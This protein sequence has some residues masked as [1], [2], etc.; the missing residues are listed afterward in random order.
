MIEHETPSDFDTLSERLLPLALRGE[1]RRKLRILAE[2]YRTRLSNLDNLFD[3]KRLSCP[4]CESV[5]NVIITGNGRGDAKK[6]LCRA[7]HDSEFTGRNSTQFRFSTYT[8]FEALKVYQD[9]FAEALTLLTTCEGTYEGVAKYLNISKHMVE[10]SVQ[11]LLDYLGDNGRD[12][13]HTNDDIVVIYADFSG[14]R[15]SRSASVIMSRVGDDIAYQVCCSMNYLTAWNFVKG[16]REK[17]N[18]KDDA[19]VIFVTDGEVAWIGPIRSFFP[20]AVH[21]RQFHSE[22]CK[23]LVYVHI[24]YGGKVYTTR[25]RWDVVLDEDKPSDEAL[26]MR[27]RRKLERSAR[28]KGVGWTE[29][30]DEIIVWEGTVKHPR[31]A[32]RKSGGATVAGAMEGENGDHG[33]EENRENSGSEGSLDDSEQFEGTSDKGLRGRGRR[34]IAPNTD[35]PKRIFRGEL[36]DALEIPVV[37][38]AFSILAAV[39]GG[40]YIT[41]NAAES[42]FNVKPALKSHR[43]VKSG[44]AFV[45]LLLFLRTKVRGW[46]REDI[47]SFFREEV[48]TFDRLRRVSVKRK[49]LR[50][51]GVDPRDVVLDAHRNGE[52]VTICYRDRNGRRTSRIIEPLKIEADPYT[53]VRRVRG[54]CYLRDDERTFLLDRVMAATPTDTDL[55]IISSEEL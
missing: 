25:F 30:S 55:S 34:I 23:G 43:T 39:F 32:R 17:L 36:E 18:V 5:K 46:G 21:V 45:Q 10:L 42:L 49:G 40:L 16:L 27:Q 52:P 24:P 54:Y 3:S 31:G 50:D 9:F 29:L 11:T 33:L 7:Q 37:R 14:T 15:V 20:D 47:K 22:N 44:E 48:V 12:S 19:T 35:G 28:S 51:D 13:I 8:S 26:R 6:L 53:G 4:I 1:T 38:Q 41:S 2:E